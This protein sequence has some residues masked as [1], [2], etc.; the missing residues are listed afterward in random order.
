MSEIRIGYS[1]LDQDT[2]ASPLLLTDA[3]LGLHILIDHAPEL[4]F[5]ERK[6]FL[7]I[8]DK[9]FKLEFKGL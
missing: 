5:P 8:N 9:C 4:C 3:I 1:K 6:V 7:K 2:L